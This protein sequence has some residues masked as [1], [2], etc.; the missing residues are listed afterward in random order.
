MESLRPVATWALV[1]IDKGASA[2][3]PAPAAET[4]FMLVSATLNV[5]GL[6]LPDQTRVV[7]RRH[8]SGCSYLCIA[9]VV[10]R[11]PRT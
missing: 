4:P 8:L 1:K 6:S 2:A 5:R 11:L 7:V 10:S 3:V 9:A